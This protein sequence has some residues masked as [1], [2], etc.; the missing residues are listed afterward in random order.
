MRKFLIALAV[1]AL[2]VTAAAV[3][4]YTRVCGGYHNPI[5]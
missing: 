2:I 4:T 5:C 3:W 1:S